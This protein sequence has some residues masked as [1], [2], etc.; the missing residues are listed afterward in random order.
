M[1]A[2]LKTVP[3]L[4]PNPAFARI[5]ADEETEALA[6]AWELVDAAAADDPDGQDAGGRSLAGSIDLQGALGLAAELSLDADGTYQIRLTVPDTLLAPGQTAVRT[7]RG[8]WEAASGGA[9]L[10]PDAHEGGLEGTGSRTLW[11]T[12]D[13]LAQTDLMGVRMTFAREQDVASGQVAVFSQTALSRLDLPRYVRDPESPVGTWL[14][15]TRPSASGATIN[16]QRI[17]MGALY[18]S[19]DGGF[20]LELSADGTYRYARG[21]VLAGG[22]WRADGDVVVLSSSDGA[23]QTRLAFGD[24]ML[25]GSDGSGVVVFQMIEQGGTPD[26]DG[27]A[28]AHSAGRGESALDAGRGDSSDN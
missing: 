16:D 18:Q 28:R 13:G 11:N 7:E 2:A 17:L 9:E 10:A 15:V 6:G 27:E 23:R 20:T 12:G 5:A 8:T 26:G 4:G 22:T 14:L 1:A 21:E 19:G 3:A 25:R 24:G